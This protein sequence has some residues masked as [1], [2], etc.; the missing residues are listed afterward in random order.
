MCHENVADLK[1]SRVFCGE[2][3]GLGDVYELVM[4]QCVA[5]QATD[6]LLA[7]LQERREA[8][9]NLAPDGYAY[10]MTLGCLGKVFSSRACR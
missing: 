6:V 1:F 5:R 3:Q 4:K 9:G 7:V 10:V 8:G 2:T